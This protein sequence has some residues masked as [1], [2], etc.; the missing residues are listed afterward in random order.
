MVCYKESMQ[1]QVRKSLGSNRGVVFFFPR[2]TKGVP[3]MFRPQPLN[4][5]YCSLSV[6]DSLF[7]GMSAIAVTSCSRDCFG[8]RCLEMGRVGALAPE[9]NKFSCESRHLQVPPLGLRQPAVSVHC[10]KAYDVVR[11]G[12]H[13][14][15]GVRLWS[16]NTPISVINP[17][18]T[19]GLLQ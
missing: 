3:V 14:V 18:V 16:L 11:S 4:T 7:C 15:S 8:A 10:L 19:G 2:G 17:F 12:R 13:S 5:I 9:R 6:S 1:L